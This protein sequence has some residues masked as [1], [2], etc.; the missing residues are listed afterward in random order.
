MYWRF[1]LF[2]SYMMC[3]LVL[4]HIQKLYVLTVLSVFQL[5]DLYTGSGTYPGS[6]DGCPR[7]DDA[8][9]KN[10][11]NLP[12]KCGDHGDCQITD[13]NTKAT[14]CICHSGY[15]GD[16]CEKGEWWNLIQIYLVLYKCPFEATIKKNCFPSQ[17]PIFR[18]KQ[19]DREF[20]FRF[21]KRL[22]DKMWFFFPLETTK[23]TFVF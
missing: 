14:I 18:T 4:G 19:A 22:T 7:E 6:T 12:K 11:V 21:K 13:Y 3:I 16:N 10:S 5:Y 15:R 20:Y 8:C 1:F 17:T 2:F 23:K 9:N